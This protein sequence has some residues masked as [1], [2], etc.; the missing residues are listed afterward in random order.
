MGVSPDGRYM[1]YFIAAIVIVFE[2]E[3]KKQVFF[4]KH[5]DDI[6]SMAMDPREGSTLVATGQKDPKEYVFK[7]FVQ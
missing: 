5:N 6:T 2:V 4:V 7:R 3:T 1:I